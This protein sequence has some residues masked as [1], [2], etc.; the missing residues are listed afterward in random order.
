MNKMSLNEAT[1]AYML[2]MISL[3]EES[4]LTTREELLLF[5]DLYDS[6]FIFHLGPEYLNFCLR[7]IRVGL[8][9]KKI[10]KPN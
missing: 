10:E 8:I 2:R 9:E 3:R 1:K 7:L 6:G 5:Q 4:K